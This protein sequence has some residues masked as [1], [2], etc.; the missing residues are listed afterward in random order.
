MQM[1]PQWASAAALILSPDS[2]SRARR[3][4][5]RFVHVADAP[6]RASRGEDCASSFD[7]SMTDDC[8]VDT[9]R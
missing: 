7:K 5:P 4:T 6:V 1:P 9:A 3:L 8:A 2:R